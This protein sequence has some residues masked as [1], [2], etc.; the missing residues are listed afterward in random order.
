MYDYREKIEQLIAPIAQDNSSGS[1]ELARRAAVALLD[2][3]GDL[4]EPEN[5]PITLIRTPIIAFAKRLLHAQPKMATLFNL[6]NRGLLTCDAHNAFGEGKAALEKFIYNFLAIIVGG[7][8]GITLHTKPLITDGAV[9]LVHSYSA[10]IIK[11]LITAKRQGKCFE[12][13]CTESRPVMEGRKT[14]T[15]LSGAGIPVTFLIDASV[16]LVLQRST[17]V[18]SGADAITIDG[19]INKV[20]TTLIGLA[21]QAADRPIYVLAD[22]TKFL[23]S[24]YHL[25]G[26][27]MHSSS[28]VWESAPE[29]VLIFNRYFEAAPLELFNGIVTEHGLLK[30]AEVKLQLTNLGVASE[31]CAEL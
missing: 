13:F 3:I 6:V 24:I 19:I 26:E 23:P 22:S 28:E 21:A 16:G 20:G 7:S 17:L 25:P 4:E 5:A 9:V 29:K 12:V 10:T 1:S 27:D 15:V 2:L 11:T 18:L 31:L 30:I 14:A 8:D